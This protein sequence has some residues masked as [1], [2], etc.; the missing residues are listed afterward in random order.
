[1]FSSRSYHCTTGLFTSTHVFIA[2]VLS[3]SL[4]CCFSSPGLCPCLVGLNF[5]FSSFF[6]SHQGAFVSYP[7]VAQI[8]WPFLTIDLVIIDG[9]R[10]RFLL[11]QTLLAGVS[12]FG[13][14]IGHGRG[15]FAHAALR[16]DH[17][18]VFG[19]KNRCLRMNFS[20]TYVIGHCRWSD[21]P[22]R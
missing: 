21:E 19:V 12:V 10:L 8:A 16:A 18:K 14:K 2:V 20:E 15:S 6:S 7:E 22:R 17:F 3:L 1:M 13:C 4:P 11:L 9:A 5:S